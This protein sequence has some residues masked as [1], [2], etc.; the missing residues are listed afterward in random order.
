MRDTGTG[1][2]TGKPRDNQQAQ[3]TGAFGA[4]DERLRR[5]QARMPAFALD[6]MRLVRMT[7]LLQKKLRDATNAALKEHGLADTGY[8]V[9]AILYGSVDETA[10]ATTLGDACQEKPANLTRLCDELC[11]RGLVAR[12]AKPGD[13]RAVLI[14]LTDAGRALIEQVLPQ[15]SN[16]V[17]A[18]YEGFS[19]AELQQLV[20]LNLRLLG[21]LEG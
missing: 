19:A 5:V 10:S 18:A 3:E 11:A 8:T 13:R 14:S 16:Q 2:Q 7:A 17:A 9:L 21:R 12:G 20:A 6:P 1:T 4:T 15:V